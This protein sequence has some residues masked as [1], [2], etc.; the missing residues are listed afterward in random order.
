MGAERSKNL[1]GLWGRAYVGPLCVF[2]GGAGLLLEKACVVVACMLACVGGCACVC[3]H[4]CECVCKRTLGLEQLLELIARVEER[5][6]VALGGAHDRLDRCEL[7]RVGHVHAGVE[8]LDLLRRPPLGLEHGV[9]R[10]ARGGGG[11]VV[12]VAVVAGA[13]VEVVVTEELRDFEGR[14]GGALDAKLRE[15][16]VWRV[17]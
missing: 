2:N 16:L 1:S 14:V 4:A 15:E 17:V 3:P 12:G 8:V 7:V 10:L 6:R 9:E 13:R 11:S 5:R